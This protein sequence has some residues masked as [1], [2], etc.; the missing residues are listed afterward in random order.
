MGIFDSNKYTQPYDV[1]R[2]N[3]EPHADDITTEPTQDQYGQTIHAVPKSLEDEVKELKLAY[4]N[5][6]EQAKARFTYDLIKHRPDNAK[7]VLKELGQING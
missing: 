4:N 3:I 6:S 5:A 7:L 1:I 2:G